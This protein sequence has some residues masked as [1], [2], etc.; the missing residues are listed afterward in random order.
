MP[1]LASVCVAW[2]TRLGC[3]L[4]CGTSKA[5]RANSCATPTLS[6]LVPPEPKWIFAVLRVT[7]HL[8]GLRDLDRCAVSLPWGAR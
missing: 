1:C 6:V 8:H 5:A 7:R 4:T 3:E 2:C